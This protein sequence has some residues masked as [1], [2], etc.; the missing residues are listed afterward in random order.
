MKSTPRG[1]GIAALAHL[2][3]DLTIAVALRAQGRGV[4][5]ALFQ[6]LLDEVMANMPHITRVELFARDS[7]VRGARCTPRSVL[8]RKDGLRARVN[9][10]RGEAE[11]DTVMGWLRPTVAG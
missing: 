5:R 9:N 6:G 11:T 7:N 4:G 10:A 8:W 3:T 1:V 2:L